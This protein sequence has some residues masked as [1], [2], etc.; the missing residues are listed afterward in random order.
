MKLCEKELA[1]LQ[2]RGADLFVRARRFLMSL[3]S[4][5]V[6]GWYVHMCNLIKRNQP[7]RTLCQ[8]NNN[9]NINNN[10]DDDDD[11]HAADDDN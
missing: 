11:D 2:R 7:I 4:S 10:D 9:N 3:Q 6:S 1:P 5:H 8:N